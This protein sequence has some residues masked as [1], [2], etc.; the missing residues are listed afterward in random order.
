[1]EA[2]IGILNA[3]E[4]CFGFLVGIGQFDKF[5]LKAISKIFLNSGSDRLEL[6]SALSL[7][8]ANLRPRR[9]RRIGRR[10]NTEEAE[11]FQLKNEVKERTLEIM[12]KSR[13]PP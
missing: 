12:T 13:A 1:M 9:N 8:V 6:T 7:F 10:H 4:L 3:S 11:K 2:I 5:F